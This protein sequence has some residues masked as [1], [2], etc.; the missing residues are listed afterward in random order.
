MKGIK[1]NKRAQGF[2][3][4]ELMIVVAIIGILAAIALPAYQTYTN[5]AKFSEV[6]AATGSVKTALDVCVQ[7]EGYTAV[8]ASGEKC[9]A[10]GNAA[11]SVVGQYITSVVASTNS[12]TGYKVTAT[13]KNIPQGTDTYTYILTGT[14]TA[15]GIKWEKDTTSTCI[16]EGY[17]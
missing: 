15:G 2:T 12:T 1:L 10:Q 3:L 16:A 5:K 14:L 17:C 13:S 7:A 4:I 9:V 8:P 6:I 11:A